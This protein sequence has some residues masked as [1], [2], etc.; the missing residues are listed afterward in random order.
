MSQTEPLYIVQTQ[1]KIL[2]PD[3]MPIRNVISENTTELTG[4]WPEVNMWWPQ[5]RKPSS[6]IAT[7]ESATAR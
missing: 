7:D 4:L 1:L 2:M 5:T 3:G 6:A